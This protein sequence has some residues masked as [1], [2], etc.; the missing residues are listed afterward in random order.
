MPRQA[1]LSDVR[2]KAALS[3]SLSPG[4]LQSKLASSPLISPQRHFFLFGSE[5]R[6][7]GLALIPVHAKFLNRADG[8][9]D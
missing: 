9:T 6:G 5:F 1:A 3:R 2:L 4:T 7:S 8:A